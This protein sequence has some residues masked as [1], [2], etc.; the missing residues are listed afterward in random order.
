MEKCVCWGMNIVHFCMQPVLAEDSK[1]FVTNL[2]NGKTDRKIVLYMNFSRKIVDS[3][4]PDVRNDCLSKEAKK[5]MWDCHD[6]KEIMQN[7]C[8]MALVSSSKRGKRD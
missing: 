1:L 8:W 2:G 5:A 3:M 7:Y 6:G 4:C